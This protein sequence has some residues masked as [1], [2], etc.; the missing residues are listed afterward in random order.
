MPP[1]F[2]FDHANHII[3]KLKEVALGKGMYMNADP[4]NLAHGQDWNKS[5]VTLAIPTK[6]NKKLIPVA[7]FQ[8]QQ[9]PGCCAIMTVSYVRTRLAVM[10]FE[11][12][13]EMIE[14]AA[15]RA[16]Y[17]S[18]VLTQVIAEGYKLEKHE[19]FPLVAERGYLMSKPFI[20][21]KSGNQVVYL[22]KDLEQAGKLAGFEERVRA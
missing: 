9:M 16:A 20:N 17:G 19:W 21:A 4:N 11:D 3:K 2:Q 7:E 1:E 15:R 8:L 18:V 5:I 6:N 13:V 22:T 10:S 12:A 14:D